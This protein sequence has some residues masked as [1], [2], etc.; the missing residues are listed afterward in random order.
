MQGNLNITGNITYAQAQVG[1]IANHNTDAL[2]EGSTNLYFTN[3][4]VDDRVASLINGGTG[5]AAVYDDANN[6]L[7]LS[8]DFGEISTS[9]LTEGTNLF[10]TNARARAAISGHAQRCA[11]RTRTFFADRSIPQ[12][13]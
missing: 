11:G 5:I 2:V 4:R 13:P 3:E 1:S 10:F 6:I 7:G 9:N 12:S 8:V